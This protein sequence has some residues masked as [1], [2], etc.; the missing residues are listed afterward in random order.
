MVRLAV[1]AAQPLELDHVGRAVEGQLDGDGGRNGD[2]ALREHLR[3]HLRTLLAH[4]RA[5]AGDAVHEALAVLVT[6]RRP[7]DVGAPALLAHEMAVGH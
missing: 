5:E 2:D 1:H 6:D 4:H 7:G 3:P